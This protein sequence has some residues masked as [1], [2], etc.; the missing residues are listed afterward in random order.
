M[1]ILSKLHQ[2]RT[3]YKSD[4]LFWE[5]IHRMQSLIRKPIQKINEYFLLA[6]GQTGEI[7]TALRNFKATVGFIRDLRDEIHAAF[8]DWEPHMEAIRTM[9]LERSRANEEKLRALYGFL[10]RN[11]PESRE[12]PLLGKPPKGGAIQ[13]VNTSRGSPQKAAA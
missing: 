8:M 2:F 10:A 5:E 3:L 4:T 9:E 6:D 1:W 13:A 12:W 11:F 7:L